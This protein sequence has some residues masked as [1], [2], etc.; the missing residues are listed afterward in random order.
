MFLKVKKTTKQYIQKNFP[1]LFQ[2]QWMSVLRTVIKHHYFLTTW[3]VDRTNEEKI[4]TRR[5]WVA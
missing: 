4:E 5:S 2:K 1:S 3:K